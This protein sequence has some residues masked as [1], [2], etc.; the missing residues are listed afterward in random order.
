[1]IRPFLISFFFIA[2][3]IVMPVQGL[4]SGMS[5]ILPEED[6]QLAQTAYNQKIEIMYA[7]MG[8]EALGLSLPV[9]SKAVTGYLNLKAQGQLSNKQLLTVIDFEKSSNQKRFWVLDL[10]NEKVLFNSLVAH[11]RN[12]GNE[13]A[14]NFSNTN[15]SYMSSL[16]FYVTDDLYYGKHGLSMK[17][18]GVDGEYNSNAMD[19]AIVMHGADYVSEDFIK[20]YGRL[21]RSLGCPALPRD[22][23]E[24]VVNTIKE[25]TCLYIHYPAKDYASKYL[26]TQFAIQEMLELDPSLMAGADNSQVSLN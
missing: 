21:G 15:E 3:A 12:T 8:V 23:N 13:F 10:E 1:M 26:N 17:L 20:K 7:E 19:R 24:D 25:G 9:F 22:L 2:I 16:G 5:I 4:E 11:G 6:P 14:R 18:R